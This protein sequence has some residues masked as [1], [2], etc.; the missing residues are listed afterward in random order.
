MD[1]NL[2][3]L[4]Y[5]YKNAEMGASVELA[6]YR[7]K[8]SISSNAYCWILCEK[9]AQKTKSGKRFIRAT[10]SAERKSATCPK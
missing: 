7:Q 5:I 9:M 1:E 4:E 8:R 6:P 3:L 2:E 10:Q